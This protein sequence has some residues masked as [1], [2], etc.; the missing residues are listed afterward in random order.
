M[1]MRSTKF[2]ELERCADGSERAHQP[3]QKWSELWIFTGTRCNLTCRSCYTESSPRNDSFRFITLEQTAHFLREAQDLGIPKICYTGG[4]PF[5]NP[6]FPAILDLT[7]ELGFQ[8]LVLTNL[9]RPYEVKGKA[10]VHRHVAAGHPL[11]IR[12]SLDHPDPEIHESAELDPAAIRRYRVPPAL[13]AERKYWFDAGF[14]RGGGN[15]RRTIGHLTDLF[16]AGARISVAGRGPQE[17]GGDLFRAYAEETEPGF[18]EL[19]ERSG[20][21]ADLSVKIFPEIGSRGD[22]NVPEITE[23]HCRTRIPESV[24]DDLMCN[25]TRMVAVPSTWNGRPNAVPLVFP[26]TIVPDNP[27]MA[28]GRTLSESIAR[29]TYLA[30]PR[31]YRFCIAGGASCSEG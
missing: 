11:H 19:F 28:L 18:R 23:H 1:T 15:F 16:S 17:V 30:D 25:Q 3:F 12:A 9:T 14:N 21:P 10:S 4:E 8:C 29:E 2:Q 31:C 6:E 5:Y 20:L 27:A 24:F 13:N 26:C 22:C 7:L